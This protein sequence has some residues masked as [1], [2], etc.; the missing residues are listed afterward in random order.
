MLDEAKG[1]HF[2]GVDFSDFDKSVPEWLI[3][4]ASDVLLINIDFV[5]YKDYGVAWAKSMIHMFER[6][7]DYFVN[8]KI[9]LRNG[10]R[11][12]KKG[13]IASGSYFTELISSIVNYILITYVTLKCQILGDGSVTGT[14]VA[15][16]LEPLGFKVKR[17]GAP[18]VI[19]RR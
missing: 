8:T 11:Y 7:T 10:E 14:D 15:R 1:S 19:T 13:G 5:H 6:I 16:H 18:R 4:L 2:L 9:R 17:Q 3:R 12:S